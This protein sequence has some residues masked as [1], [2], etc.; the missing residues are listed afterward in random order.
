[1]DKLTLSL[2]RIS[3]C[4]LFFLIIA[5]ILLGCEG[6]RGPIGKPGLDG[7]T[8][9][10]YPAYYE[11]FDPE[12][13]ALVADYEAHLGPIAQNLASFRLV[14]QIKI[15]RDNK[16]LVNVVGVCFRGRRRTAQ[17]ESDYWWKAHR[18]QGKVLGYHE[19]GHCLQ[20]A[21]H[22]NT[23]L[24]GGCPSIMNSYVPPTA[25]IIRCWDTMINDMFG[26]KVY[27]NTYSDECFE[28]PDGTTAC[29]I[30]SEPIKGEPDDHLFNDPNLLLN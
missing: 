12:L 3:I 1:M 24:S 20:A 26:G 29:A 8:G 11:N 9:A 15:Y 13:R 18:V 17:I 5:T 22:K 4:S 14:P 21:P 16:L 10:R 19:L 28:Q 25:D 7:P 2:I 23:R 6:P 30:F 27:L